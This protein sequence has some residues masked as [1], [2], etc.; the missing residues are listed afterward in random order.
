MNTTFNFKSHAV[1][2][3]KFKPLSR[4]ISITFIVFT[5]LIIYQSHSINK[6]LN[7]IQFALSSNKVLTPKT[8]IISPFLLKY[9]ILQSSLIPQPSYLLSAHSPS[10]TRLPDGR[11]I[12]VWFA[13]THEGN[14]DVKIWQSY[15][16]DNHWTAAQPIVRREDITRDTGLFV[17]KL[18]NPVIYLDSHNIL[19]LFVV[20]VA[21]GGW[22][23][24]VINHLKSY[25]MGKAWQKPQRL[26]LTPF[27][28][29]STLIRTTPVTLS[30][31][32]FYLPI[33][34]EFINKYPELLYFDSNGDLVYKKRITP[35]NKLIQPSILPITQKDAIVYFRN[36]TISNAPL[37]Y[38]TT[39][40][41]GISWGTLLSTNL[42]NQ[43]SSLA[44]TKIS[45]VYL[46]V[47]NIDTRGYLVLSSSTDGVTWL[48]VLTLEHKTPLDEF[49][50]PSISVYNDII[51]IV[52]TWQRKYIK[53]ARILVS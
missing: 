35:Q 6:K 40:D 2:V 33:Y 16:I 26:Y 22:S 42:H 46:M 49:S 10:I 20:S 19:H 11:L 50:Y 17:K 1:K 37:M 3:M 7:N 44:T 12:A 30:D 48:D 29:V 41:A 5:G 21:T 8:S 47:R 51:D 43:D 14:P 27:F 9:K 25:D 24:S 32:G 39:K 34:H 52:Y 15:F 53:H 13:G 4:I 36:H 45:G 18:G 23:G 38:A 31:G 28:N